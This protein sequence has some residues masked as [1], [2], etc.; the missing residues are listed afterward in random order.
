MKRFKTEHPNIV[1]GENGYYYY[2]SGK[3]FISLKTRDFTQAL[4]RYTKI[5]IELDRHGEMALKTTVGPIMDAYNDFRKNK[6]E[7]KLAKEKRDRF[8]TW[9]EIDSVIRNHLKTFFGEMKLSEIDPTIWEDYCHQSTVSD[10]TNHRKVMKG[11][12]SWCKRKKYIRHMPDISWIPH[13][14]KRKRKILSVEQLL[15]VFS[16]AD[17]GLLLFLMFAGLMGLRR[18]EIITLRW[19]DIDFQNASLHVRE[20]IAKTL[21]SVRQIP[22]NQYVFK[23]LIRRRSEVVVNK[24]YQASPWVFPN[25]RDPRRHM[26]PAG[27]M[28]PWRKLLKTKRE[29]GSYYFHDRN[30]T[31]HD[32]RA[33]YEKHLNK[34]TGS[35]DTQK[36]KI[37]GASIDVQKNIYVTMDA[38]DLR[39]LSDVVEVPGLTKLLEKKRTVQKNGEQ[40]ANNIIEIEAG[41]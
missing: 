37:A 26:D 18:T 8:R 13:H 22:V 23:E 30:I 2:R 32:L 27:F 7:G 11:F 17:D 4:E 24:R 10:L 1:L 20:E 12:L 6:M 3:K 9:E 16:L 39:A 29:D 28:N 19:Q 21:S 15:T 14:K 25:K 36:E 33:T 41:K 34:H 31:W 40:T 38:D 35:T 5:A